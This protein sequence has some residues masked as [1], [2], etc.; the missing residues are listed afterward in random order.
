MTVKCI[1]KATQQAIVTDFQQGLGT[2]GGMA[3]FLGV[4]RRTI[5][6]VLEDHGVEP[7]IKR[8]PGAQKP[9]KPIATEAQ[10]VMDYQEPLSDSLETAFFDIHN[11]QNIAQPKLSFFRRVLTKVSGALFQR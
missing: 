6:R 1:P 9:R 5:I 10:A 3:D 4:S 8:R 2:I 7:G 11:R